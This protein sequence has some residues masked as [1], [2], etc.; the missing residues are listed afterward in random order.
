MK[1]KRAIIIKDPKLQK[2]RNNLRDI[3]IAAYHV[4]WKEIHNKWR[5]Y[6]FNSD[7]SRRVIDDLSPIE[8]KEFRRLQ[9]R[10]S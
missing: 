3:L 1:D 5:S 8:L 6:F 9:E 7:G 10:E 4:Q 2:I